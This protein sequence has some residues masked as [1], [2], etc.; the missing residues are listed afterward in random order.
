M[1]IRANGKVLELSGTMPVTQLLAEAQVEMPDYVSVQLNEV[2]LLRSDFDQTLVQEGDEV[3]FL[4]F[5]GG[6]FLW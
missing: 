6:G 5:M 4:Y 3:E 1:R 2:M